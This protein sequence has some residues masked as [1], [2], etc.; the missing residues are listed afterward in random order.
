MFDPIPLGLSRAT[1]LTRW[2]LP[3][4][5]SF[6]AVIGCLAVA[7][8]LV[9]VSKNLWFAASYV[10]L[11]AACYGIESVDAR[12]FRLIGLALATHVRCARTWLRWG[13]WSVYS[14]EPRRR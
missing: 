14:P 4:G 7:A 1:I 3:I 2:G 6:G 13:G 11:H 10:V 8:V 9:W 5:I 12:A